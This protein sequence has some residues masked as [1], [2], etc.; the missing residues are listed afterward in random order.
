M[1]LLLGYIIPYYLALWS[2]TDKTGHKKAPWLEGTVCFLLFLYQLAEGV[3]IRAA[4][5][6]SSI[7]HGGVVIVF[8]V[9]FIQGEGDYIK[10]RGD[11]VAVL[12]EPELDTNLNISWISRGN[13][14]G[15]HR[16]RRGGGVIGFPLAVII[17][18]HRIAMWILTRNS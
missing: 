11:V 14:A 3:A 2:F 16:F 15:G 10:A 1:V 17:A 7:R 4:P 6:R 13:R 18:P 5:S 8:K 9:F 12:G